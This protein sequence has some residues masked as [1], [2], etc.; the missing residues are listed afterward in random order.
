[1]T[2]YYFAEDGNYGDAENITLVEDG[3]FDRHLFEVLE[4]TT[5]NDRNTF[6]RWFI[7]NPHFAISTTDLNG[8][9]YGVCSV[10]DKFAEENL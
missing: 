5:D 6:V 10:C 8:M 4:G 1:M 9:S 2:K 7:A 3:Q